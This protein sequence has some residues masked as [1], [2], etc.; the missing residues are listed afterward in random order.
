[1][2]LWTKS[3][4]PQDRDSTAPRII[5][6]LLSILAAIAMVICMMMIKTAN[7]TPTIV[8]VFRMHGSLVPSARV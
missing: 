6:Q 1:L 5:I 3:H 7:G 2:T 4:A 8:D